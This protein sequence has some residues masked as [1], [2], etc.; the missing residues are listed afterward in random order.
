M[1]ILALDSS[2]EA[3]SAAVW[4]GG[5]R[6][7][8]YLCRENKHSETLMTAVDAALRM[9]A[10]GMDDIGLVAVA[11]G[12]GSFTGLRI[13]MAAAKGLAQARGIA[14]VGVDT[15]DVLARNVAGSGI[16]APIMDA[17]RGEVYSAAFAQGGEIMPKGARP[18]D[19]LLDALQQ[20]G[21]AV[22]FVG[23]GVPVH[24]EAIV[25]RLGGL[26]QF[27]PGQLLLQRAGAVAAIAAE[28]NAGDYGDAFSVKAEYYRLS[29]AERVRAE[30]EAQP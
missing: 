6:S 22:T 8:A 11:C 18:L 29:Q 24:R 15:L 5:L 7:E 14:C 12:P 17:R 19:E 13:G 2:G 26:A 25:R 1:N 21:G 9:A 10:V 23:D 20:E 3:A 27:A 16:V 4:S 28:M 30:R